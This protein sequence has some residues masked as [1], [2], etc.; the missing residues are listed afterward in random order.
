MILLAA[1][2]GLLEPVG[3]LGDLPLREA[4][5]DG[6]DH[7]AHAVDR[8]EVRQRLGFHVARQPLDEVRA[9][10]RIDDVGD[11]ASRAR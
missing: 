10:E 4:L 8:V 2:D 1:L 9:A 6:R 11:A 5:L 7:A 3:A